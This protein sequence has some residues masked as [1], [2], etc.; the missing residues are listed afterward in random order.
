MIQEIEPGGIEAYRALFPG[1]QLEMV[2]ASVTAGNT[3]ARLWTGDGATLLWDQ[4]NNVF[5]LAGAASDA[6]ALKALIAGPIRDEALRRGRRYFRARGLA[7]PLHARLP[8]LFAP[9]ALHVTNKRFYRYTG[10]AP[11]RAPDPEGIAFVPIDGVLL[12]TRG[13]ANLGQV[14]HEIGLMWPSEA[15][16][17]EKGFGVAA[18][19]EHTIIGWCTAEYASRTMCGIGIETLE[20]YQRRG[21]ATAAA[22]RFVRHALAHGVAP[23]WECDAKNLPSVRV[24]EK[25]GFTL[26]EEATFWAGIF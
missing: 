1:Q 6:G 23:H 3:T 25:T 24:A 4:G 22:R 7:A 12:N 14:R 11:A 21:I 18:L 5:Y 10:S 16:F 26:V 9:T 8:E 15:L 17:F 19:A 13:L 2:I 20:D